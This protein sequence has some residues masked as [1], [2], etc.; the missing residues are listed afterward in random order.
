[1]RIRWDTVFISSVLFTIAMLW[2]VPPFFKGALAG[3]DKAGLKNLD[4]GRRLYAQ[5]GGSFGVAS[6]AIILIGLIV[7][8]AGYIKKVRWTWFVMFVIVWGWAFPVMAFPDFA[9]MGGCERSW[10]SHDTGSEWPLYR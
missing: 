1:M 3:Y 5:M 10:A 7:T 6:L 4:T 8:W 2:C 9:G